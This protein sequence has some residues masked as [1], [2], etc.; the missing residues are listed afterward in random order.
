MTSVL[1]NF[2]LS[3]QNR[4]LLFGPPYFSPSGAVVRSPTLHCVRRNLK[5]NIFNYAK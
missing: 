2:D 5:W 3:S 4:A 1:Q